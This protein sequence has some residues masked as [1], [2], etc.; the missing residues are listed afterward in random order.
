MTR[1]L[2]LLFLLNLLAQETEL[3][4]AEADSLTKAESGSQ[5]SYLALLEDQI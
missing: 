4:F 2:L 3:L 5:G 1:L